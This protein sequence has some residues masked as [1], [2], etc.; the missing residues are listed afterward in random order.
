GGGGLGE[1]DAQFARTGLGMIVKR[2]CFQIGHVGGFRFF[3]LTCRRPSIRKIPS[4]NKTARR[5]TARHGRLPLSAP[6]AAAAGAPATTAS[7]HDPL[8]QNVARQPNHAL[9]RAVPAARASRWRRILP[10]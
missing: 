7:V 8:R 3:W 10:P 4:T 5:A 2:G 1:L 9:P 6:A